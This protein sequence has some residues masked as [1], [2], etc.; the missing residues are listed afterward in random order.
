[1]ATPADQLLDEALKLA[2]DDRA[3]LATELLATLEPDVPSE[4]RDERE[5]VRE[6]ERRARAAMAGN[7][8]L[9]WTEAHDQVLSR[10]AIR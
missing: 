9:S 6:I 7:T 4:R 10:L 8:G 3:K 2:P 5:W 1:M